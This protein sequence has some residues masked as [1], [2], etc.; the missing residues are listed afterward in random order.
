MT[1]CGQIAIVDYGMGNLR[2]VQNAVE[3]VGGRAD[4]VDRPSDLA[5]YAKIILPGVGAFAEAIDRL[6]S[7]G[8]VDALEERKRAGAQILGIC[9]GMQL[10]CTSSEEN[11]QHKGLGWFR[12]S[13]L[14]FIPQDGLSVPHM[15]WNSVEF[16]RH[17]EVLNGLESGRDAYFVHSYY[18]KC[19]SEE[20]VLAASTY[21]VYFHSI[22]QRNNLRGI[23]F[24]PE[25]SQDMGL[26]II[27]DYL[28]IQC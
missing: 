23:Q 15:G 27:R 1:L 25:K 7:A 11:G 12:A 20:D 10:M 14:P 28:G 24:H 26:S 6:R 17:D 4:I 16:R 8:L 18:V 13:V 5:A 19:E 2:S 3:H 22:I 21:N 9:L